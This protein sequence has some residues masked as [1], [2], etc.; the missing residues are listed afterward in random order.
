MQIRLSW[1]NLETGEWQTPVLT[2]PIALGRVFER[3]PSTVNGE[4]VSRIVLTGKES[5]VFMG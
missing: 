5:R 3:M 2:L 4:K 1:Q